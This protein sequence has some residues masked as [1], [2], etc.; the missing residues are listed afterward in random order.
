VKSAHCRIAPATAN[1]ARIRLCNFAPKSD[2]NFERGLQAEQGPADAGANGGFALI[3]EQLK[4][5]IMA[6]GVEAVGT[7]GDDFDPHSMEAIALIFSETIP[8]NRVVEVARRGYRWNNR[9]LR[10]ALVVVSRGQSADGPLAET[11]RGSDGE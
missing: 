10:P 1:R 6:R 11:S 8:A 2:A 5:L 3:F 7:A 4:R 9:L